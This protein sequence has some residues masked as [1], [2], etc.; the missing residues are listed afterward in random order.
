MHL[1]SVATKTPHLVHLAKPFFPAHAP[2][3]RCHSRPH[4]RPGAAVAMTA[5][6][7]VFLFC[8]VIGWLRGLS[9]HNGDLL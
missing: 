4:R 6:S 8:F 7:S 3:P 2:S 9:F 1:A 5:S